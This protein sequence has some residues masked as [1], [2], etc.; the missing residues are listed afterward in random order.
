MKIHDTV[1]SEKAEAGKALIE[2][3]KKLT[4]SD[5]VSI[6]AYRGFEMLLFYEAF[7]KEY[8]VSLKGALSHTISLG[9]DVHGNITRLDN[10]LNGME[11]RLQECRD[12]LE[13]TKIQMKAAKAE[14]EKPFP[15]AE[16]LR[17]KSK[18]LAELTKLLKM[19]EKDRELLDGE[20][21]A[22]DESPER[23]VAGLER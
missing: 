1:Y 13:N 2:A 4:N 8:R 20:P 17:E 21:D 14:S 22:G 18:R 12:R 5:P 6:G 19:D 16:E 11:A 15:R 10:A 23:K 7:A 3:C 9:T